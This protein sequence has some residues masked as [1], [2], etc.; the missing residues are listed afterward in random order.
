LS[1]RGGETP[2]PDLFNEYAIFYSLCTVLCCLVRCSFWTS[3]MHGESILASS[4]ARRTWRLPKRADAPA[5][6]DSAAL[7]LPP[8]RAA[9]VGRCTEHAIT[10][11][12]ARARRRHLSLA[13][14]PKASDRMAPSGRRAS[15]VAAEPGV[16]LRPRALGRA[17]ATRRPTAAANGCSLR[18]RQVAVDPAR[19]CQERATIARPPPR[20]PY[21]SD[22]VAA[23]RAGKAYSFAGVSVARW[24]K[25]TAP[26]IARWDVPFQ[27]KCSGPRRLRTFRRRCLCIGSC[28]PL[29]RTEA[30]SPEARDHPIAKLDSVRTRGPSIAD[31]PNRQRSVAVRLGGPS[32]GSGKR[33]D[34][35][36]CRR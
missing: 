15:Q 7:G 8:T 30:S 27:S 23:S 20:W 13:H 19:T 28:R 2:G 3:Y 35:S 17:G 21:P 1:A 33:G 11:V 5:S 36:L 22:A 9:G 29:R 10:H 16:S 12:L 6:F 34:G 25:W 24:A 14:G 18:R 32:V 26:C 4:I 31:G